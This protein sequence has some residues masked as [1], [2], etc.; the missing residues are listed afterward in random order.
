M[1]LV[2]WRAAE[3]W[4]LESRSREGR[5]QAVVGVGSDPRERA[6]RADTEG[7]KPSQWMSRGE[8]GARVRRVGAEDE[9]SAEGKAAP[10]RIKHQAAAR[11]D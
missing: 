7:G 5:S 10:A 3:R 4:E 8:S 6:R 1:G 11:V 2:G 9:G